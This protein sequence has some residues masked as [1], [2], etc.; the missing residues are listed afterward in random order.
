MIS[1]I[2]CSRNPGKDV[3]LMENINSTIGHIEYE[4]I[5]ID[6]SA[7][8]MSIFQA[9]DQGVALARYDYLCFMHEDVLFHSDDWGVVCIDRMRADDNIGLLGVAGS[10]YIARN[11]NYWSNAWSSIKGRILQGK[12][13]DGKYKVDDTVFGNDSCN[14]NVVAIDGVWL[15]TKRE[16]FNKNLK[17]DIETYSDFHFYDMDISMQV[18]KAGYRIE[19]ISVLIEHKSDGKRSKSF[20]EN[21]FKFHRK[22]DFFLPQ[23]TAELT[24]KVIDDHDENVLY[25]MY[26]NMVELYVMR[27]KKD[28]LIRFL[29]FFGYNRIKKMLGR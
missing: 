4:V 29:S 25:I 26:Q 19:V 5:W 14:R 1:I 28:K 13:V 6:N 24:Q 12:T 16:L 15:F 21:C 2:I 10:I 8:K 20:W 7:G 17:W 22:W 3:A 11:T 27:E 9:Y 23:A 18:L